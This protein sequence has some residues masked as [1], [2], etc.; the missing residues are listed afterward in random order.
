MAK[1]LRS[2]NCQGAAFCWFCRQERAW[3]L[4]TSTVCSEQRGQSAAF[5]VVQAEAS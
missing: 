5:P 2:W 1:T 4:Q 3:E